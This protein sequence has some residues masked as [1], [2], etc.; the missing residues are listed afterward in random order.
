MVEMCWIMYSSHN[1]WQGQNVSLVKAGFQRQKPKFQ[2][3][4]KN[5]PR[6]PC[7]DDIYQVSKKSEG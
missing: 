5:S 7:R 2:N 1:V 6:E 4:S 3:L